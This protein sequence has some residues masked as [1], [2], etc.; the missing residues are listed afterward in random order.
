MRATY[1]SHQRQRDKLMLI[2]GLD[3]RM[4]EWEGTYDIDSLA[5]ALEVDEKGQP[6]ASPLSWARDAAVVKEEVGLMVL[7][8]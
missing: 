3:V 1:R 5:C 2:D 4:S 8:C 6:A 7:I